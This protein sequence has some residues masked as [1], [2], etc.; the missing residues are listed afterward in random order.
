MIQKPTTKTMQVWSKLIRVEQTLLNVIEDR[1]KASGLPSLKWYDILLELDRNED[2]CLRPKMLEDSLLLSQY[3][4]SRLLDRMSKAGLVTS[5][6]DPK[7][8]RAQIIQITQTGREMKARI[9][10]V[11]G[12]FIQDKIGDR[13]NTDE[14]DTLIHLLKKLH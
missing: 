10:A 14:T 11:Y 4:I 5:R 9:W 8:K 1:L 3:N 7:D 2:G 13:L 12:P 6:P